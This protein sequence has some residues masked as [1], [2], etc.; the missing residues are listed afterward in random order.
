[1][2]EKAALK[3]SKMKSRV[4]AS[5]P[6]TIDHPVSPNRYSWRSFSVSRVGAAAALKPRYVELGKRPMPRAANLRI[7]NFVL[8]VLDTLR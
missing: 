3:S 7:K 6:G 1:M 2:Y 4:I 8:N 5:R